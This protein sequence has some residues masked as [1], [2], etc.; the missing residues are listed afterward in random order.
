[1]LNTRAREQRLR[2]RIDFVTDEKD[3]ALEMLWQAR[4][5]IERLEKRV[6]RQYGEN[7]DLRGSREKWRERAEAAERLISEIENGRR[8]KP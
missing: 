3:A 2:A 6:E 5:D 4:D 8:K 7:R 1:M